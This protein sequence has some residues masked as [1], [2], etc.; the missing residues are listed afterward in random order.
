M[1][2]SARS[3][4]GDVFQ[5]EVESATR[6]LLSTMNVDLFAENGAFTATQFLGLEYIADS[7]GNTTLYGLTRSTTN[8][9]GASGS[10]FAPE[11]APALWKLQTGEHLKPVESRSC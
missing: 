2:E 11:A 6:A 10:E 8:L 1:I 3:G 9:L 5:A 7:T 4:V